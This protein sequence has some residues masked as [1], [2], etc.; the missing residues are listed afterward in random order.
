[1]PVVRTATVI[2]AEGSTTV[3]LSDREILAIH[4]RRMEI[5]Y[6]KRVLQADG[7]D[8]MTVS[9]QLNN[10]LDEPIL[11][12]R[13]FEA[14]LPDQT[15]RTFSTNDDGFIK[16]TVDAVWAGRYEIAIRDP[17]GVW[18]TKHLRIEAV[19]HY[20]TAKPRSQFTLEIKEREA[21]NHQVEEDKASTSIMDDILAA[22]TMEDFRAVMV[23]RERRN[24][25][26]ETYL[27]KRLGI[28]PGDIK[29]ELGL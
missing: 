16:F 26:L 17:E 20:P 29:A 28:D 5:S 10:G 8:V 11:E 4:P 25:I 23:R 1:M 3:E 12:A 21:Y 7:A 6:S 9:I 22:S 27:M 24:I 2:G 15:V 14:L 18:F 13:L 19:G